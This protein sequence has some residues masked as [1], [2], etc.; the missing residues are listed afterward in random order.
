MQELGEM[1]RAA[2][3]EKGLTLADAEEATRI[4]QRY[5]EALEYGDEHGLPAPVYVEGF[6]RG[7]A[8]YLGLPQQAVLEKCRAV[9]KQREGAPT[10]LRLPVREIRMPGTF[11]WARVLVIA[12]LLAVVLVGG[13]A[14]LQA[15]LPLPSWLPALVPAA[16][17]PPAY[18]GPTPT[19]GPEATP[20][21]TPATAAPPAATTPEPQ[22]TAVPT[23]TPLPVVTVQ[24]LT[25]SPSWLRVTVD[26]QL[27]YEGTLDAGISR[28]WTGT[29]TVSIRAGNA[30]G[31]IVTVNG[32]SRGPFGAP[33]EVVDISWSAQ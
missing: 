18:I 31:T 12:A 3:Q 32:I 5:L 14:Y 6:L 26:D 16:P 33:G 4:R 21:P 29:R 1:L 28:A 22:P 20:S 30:G 24:V 27:A 7:Y 15:G 19:E 17:P 25:T 9:Q 8:A 11:N 23:S 13:S 2:R 10:S